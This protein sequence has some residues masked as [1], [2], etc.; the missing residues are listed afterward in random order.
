[1]DMDE[2]YQCRWATGSDY[3]R[4]PDTHTFFRDYYQSDHPAGEIIPL[5]EK[6]LHLF[7]EHEITATFFFTGEIA[8]YYP[9]L[10][11]EIVHDGH[12]I[13]SHNY[14]HRDYGE[15]NALEFYEN[16]KKSKNV[17]E[18]LS[19]QEIIGYRAPNSTVANYMIHDL[20]ELG[21]TYDSS[22]T[23]TRPFMGKFGKHTSAPLNPYQV[24]QD[25]FARPG[26]S[27]LWEFPWPVFPVLNLPAGSG[28]M[29]RI[30][31]Y[32]YTVISLD[33]AL[34]TGDSVYYFH[35]YEIGPRP[36]LDRLNVK[37]RIFLKDLGDSYLNMLGK[38]ITRYKGQFATGATLFHQ[39]TQKK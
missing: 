28:I 18:K 8:S 2:W 1:V 22:I 14:L 37:T 24:A 3:A 15:K 5:T 32:R 4:W 17:L 31:G 7:N 6:I 11:K 12:E 23:P 21:F 36:R 29:S 35:P 10:V 30:A 13:A 16:A 39:H 20:V 26:T 25:D 33:H 34:R 27:G 9:D 19:G 38:L